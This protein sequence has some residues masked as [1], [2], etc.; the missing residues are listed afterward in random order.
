MHLNQKIV[1]GRIS[2]LRGRNYVRWHTTWQLCYKK[3]YP[4]AVSKFLIDRLTEEHWQPL[5]FLWFPSQAAFNILPFELSPGAKTWHV[6]GLWYYLMNFNCMCIDQDQNL[7]FALEFFY[8]RQEKSERQR[9]QI[10][11]LKRYETM[12]LQRAPQHALRTNLFIFEGMSNSLKRGRVCEAAG[13]VEAGS[14][15]IIPRAQDK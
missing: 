8:R 13:R 5:I 3:I 7:T 14:E 15:W 4:S 6:N 10:T 1:D 9:L 2:F 11:E 12:Y